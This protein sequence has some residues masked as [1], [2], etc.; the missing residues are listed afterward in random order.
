ML[1]IAI[2]GA[3]LSGLTVAN[4]LSGKANVTLFE[5]SAGVGGRMSTRRAA[6]YFFDH[7][8]QFFKIKSN[9]FEE[10]LGPML[11][12]NKIKIWNARFVIF[13]N[14]EV[15]FKKKW[16]DLCQ[17]WSTLVLLCGRPFFWER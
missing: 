11:E 14:R 8:A 7:G 6:P 13:K 9:A 5:K 10:F 3:G 4:K 16:N 2:I 1:T 17:L 12:S 15:V